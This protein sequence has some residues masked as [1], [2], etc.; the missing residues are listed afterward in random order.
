[1]AKRK[2]VSLKRKTARRIVSEYKYRCK[3]RNVYF[4]L[5]EDEVYRLIF[6]KCAYCK[7]PPRNINYRHQIKYNGLDRKDN[8]KGYTKE[9]VV[10]SCAVCNAV[11][12][13]L[14]TYSEMIQVG[15]V[16]SKRTTGRS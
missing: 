1:M 7:K 4:G 14:L 10:T 5:S 9:N 11:K 6:K 3:T 15:R 13:D 16:L 8:Y 12:S 2:P